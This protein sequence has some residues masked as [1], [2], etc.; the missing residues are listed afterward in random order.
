[1]AEHATPQP[2]PRP[3]AEELHWGI[4][5]LRADIQDLASLTAAARCV[6]L[7]WPSLRA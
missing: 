1:M 5:Y 7:G 4:S 2:P 3:A 6:Y